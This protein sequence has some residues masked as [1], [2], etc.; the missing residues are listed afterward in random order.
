MRPAARL[1]NLSTKIAAVATLL[2]VLLLPQ[3]VFP[4]TPS[5][6]PVAVRDVKLSSDKGGAKIVVYLSS[7]AKF[8]ESR[9]HDPERF[10]V[11]LKD[12]R[13][14]GNFERDIR[15]EAGLVRAVR[16]GQ[17]DAGTVRIVADMDIRNYRYKV[18]VM[19]D[20]PRVVIDISA[21]APAGKR[22]ALQVK[23]DSTGSAATGSQM[24][25][26]EKMKDAAPVPDGTSAAPKPL[27]YKAGLEAEMEG[28]WKQAL[29]IYRALVKNEPQNA[30]L[31]KR[32]GELEWSLGNAAKA[33]D[34]LKRAADLSPRDAALL[35]RVSK[36]YADAN[37]PV[38]AFGPIR[39]AVEL[40]PGNIEYLRALAQIANWNGRSDIA[41]EA[42]GKIV[43]LSPRD[44]DAQLNLARSLSW[45]GDLDAA[46]AVFRSYCE[47]HPEKKEVLIEYAEAEGWR[48]NYPAELK[49]L[50]RYRR[51]FGDTKEYRKA[52]A[53]LLAWAE[54]PTTALKLID[55]LLKE[56]PDDYDVNYSNTIALYYGHRLPEAVRSLQTLEKLRPQSKETYD[57]RRFVTTAVRSNVEAGF[58][59]YRDSDHLALY[60]TKLKGTCFVN[61]DTYLQARGEYD[62]LHADRGSGY[63]TLTGGT[64]SEQ[65]AAWIGAG[66]RLSPKLAV[67]GRIGAASVK[68]GS[69]IGVYDVSL[70]IQA[71]D[72][73][74]LRLEREH[75]YY[76]VSPR[77]LSLGIRSNANMLNLTWQ[78]DLNYT[79][80]STVRYVTLSDDNRYWEIGVTPRR[81][82]LRREK[83]NL[84]LGVSGSWLT[85]DKTLNNGYYNPEL[86]QRYAAVA[87]GY[88]KINDDNGVS[89][90]TSLGAQKDNTMSSFRLSYDVG[91]EGTFGIYRDW[92]LKVNAGYAHNVR[93]ASGAFEAFGG[94][95]SI[96]RRF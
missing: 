1:M 67:Q 87:F 62:Y 9:L 8:T 95:L 31:W 46:V 39:K 44:E 25:A 65:T 93:Q 19:D 50:E 27:S 83:F 23:V 85:Y 80:D 59:F 17:F 64:F 88:W 86:E 12:A 38:N 53:R 40:D 30:D 15:R 76:L 55:P 7:T 51:N 58:Q 82:V 84:D 18:E 60:S 71:A 22:P 92:M 35:A 68:D 66:R 33:A 3:A 14:A 81:S 89:I 70:D 43:K 72:E 21:P 57:I 41:A 36:A 78:P 49:L 2:L 94:G 32:I 73:L 74:L 34:A 26:R 63:E 4:A 91:A 13:I 61:P 56:S 48:G 28:Q 42:Y 6:S 90:T 69:T 45:S 24:A 10:Y 54:R 75:G 20:P 11:D 47:K 52:M 37:D 5:R 79:I 77:T 16:A 29:E 96:T